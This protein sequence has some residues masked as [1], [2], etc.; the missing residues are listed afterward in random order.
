MLGIGKVLSSQFGQSDCQLLPCPGWDC[1]ALFPSATLRLDGS[2]Y[3]A[4]PAKRPV[5]VAI[6]FFMSARE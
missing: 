2:W 1:G 3:L 4:A 6:S 5:L